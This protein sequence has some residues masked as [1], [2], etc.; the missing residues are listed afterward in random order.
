MKEL[1]KLLDSISKK[2]SSFR[3]KVE[4]EEKKVKIKFSSDWFYGWYSGGD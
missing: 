4:N 1:K 2:N 3:K